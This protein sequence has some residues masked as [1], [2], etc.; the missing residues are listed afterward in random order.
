MTTISLPSLD[1]DG[2]LS[3]PVIQALAD[4]ATSDRD[5]NDADKII[6]TFPTK[7]AA[8]SFATLIAGKAPESTDNDPVAE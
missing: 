8:K 4:G 3:G 6:L 2:T 5:P 1:H 7:A